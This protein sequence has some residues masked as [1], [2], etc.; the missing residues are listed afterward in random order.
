MPLVIAHR[1]ASGHRPEHTR[2][3]YLL[4]IDGGAHAIEPDLVATRDGVLVIRHENELSTTT[5]VAAH[6]E[7]AD[8]RRST[9]VDGVG[10]TGWFTEDF[11]WAELETLAA[12]ERI[13]HLRPGNAQWNGSRLLRLEDAAAIVRGTGVGLVLELK[14][15]AH[16]AALGLDLADLL[17]DALPGLDGVPLWVESFELGVLDR[18]RE[19]VDLP[20]VFLA[21]ARGTP[22]DDPRGPAWADHLAPDGLRALRDRVGGVSVDKS[23][24]LD[25]RGDATGLADRIHDA[26][27]EAWT[28]T[29]RPENHFLH[30]VNRRG[31]DP[32]ARGDY[33]REFATLIRQTDAVFAD[34][35]S[36]IPTSSTT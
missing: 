11:T 30:P 25:A 33:A 2:E 27:L 31:D 29:L 21:E 19:R 8:R 24:L 5:D 7:F 3:A 20:F 35:P 26:S 6:P 22:A 15:A 12:C 4:A 16:F 10:F 28:W 32:A 1:G 13:P 17:L 14:H 34:H 18:L 36:L 9:A 23:L